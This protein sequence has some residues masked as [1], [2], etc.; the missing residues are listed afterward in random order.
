[1]SNNLP[2]EPEV[3]ILGKKEEAA[4]FSK[5]LRRT[6]KLRG[7]KSHNTVTSMLTL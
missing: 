3:S 7:V 2:D 6:E 4:R 1:M 5:M